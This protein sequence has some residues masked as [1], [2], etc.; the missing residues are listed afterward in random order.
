M[1]QLTGKSERSRRIPRHPGHS[2]RSSSEQNL[3]HHLAAS[4]FDSE[5]RAMAHMGLKG[6]NRE[7]ASIQGEATKLI[8]CKEAIMQTR[9]TQVIE[10]KAVYLPMEDAKRSLLQI[11]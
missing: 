4:T 7:I 9:S 11:T 8:V 1:L 10:S 5:A 2:S 6:S 3:F